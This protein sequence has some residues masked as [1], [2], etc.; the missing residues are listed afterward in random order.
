MA[1]AAQSLHRLSL[2][3]KV[4]TEL[5]N[6][7]GVGD[8]TL[9]EFVV[10]MCEA[11]GSDD[12]FGKAVAEVGAEMPRALVARLW[13]LIQTME[14]DHGAAAAQASAGA[15]EAARQDAAQFRGLAMEDT[16]DRARGGFSIYRRSRMDSR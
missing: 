8:A 6:H 5:E 7:L 13:R 15:D 12:D 11:S 16:A 14:G 2:I 9:A 10:S 1:A 3:S 4:A